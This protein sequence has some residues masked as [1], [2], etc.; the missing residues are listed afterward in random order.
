MYRGGEKGDSIYR[1]GALQQDLLSSGRD[2]FQE[3]TY[4][5]K[6]ISITAKGSIFRCSNV[7]LGTRF[8]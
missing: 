3:Q 1:F 7:A 8:N 5:C 4:E 2:P 6:R